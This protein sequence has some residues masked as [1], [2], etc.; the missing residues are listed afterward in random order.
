MILAANV[1]LWGAVAVMLGGWDRIRQYYHHGLNAGLVSGIMYS[2][3]NPCVVIRGKVAYEGDEV[4][5]YKILRI[6]NN[7]VE[8]QKD[9]RYFRVRP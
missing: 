7:E 5:G 3:D 4:D 6:Y 9:G 1:L 8:L 2:E